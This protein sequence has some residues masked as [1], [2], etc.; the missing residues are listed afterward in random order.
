MGRLASVGV[1][2][3][4]D[5]PILHRL[6]SSSCRF[7]TRVLSSPFRSDCT[8]RFADMVWG[9]PPRSL[10]TSPPHLALGRFSHRH[11]RPLQ[12]RQSQLTFKGSCLTRG[13][14]VCSIA[15]E[16]SA[17]RVSIWKPRRLAYDA[18]S[19]LWGMSWSDRPRCRGQNGPLLAGHQTS[20][21]CRA[22]GAYC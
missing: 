14:R 16:S 6:G 22:S 4:C 7:G 11:R 13:E 17:G 15:G 3:S 21:N 20:G 12:A 18:A 1:L 10:S 19:E 9:R 5:W 8:V 2:C